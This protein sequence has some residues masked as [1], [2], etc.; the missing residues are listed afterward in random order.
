[1]PLSQTLTSDKQ[2]RRSRRHT[3]SG[4]SYVEV[5]AAAILMSILL[6]ASLR[7][8]GNLGRSRQHTIDRDA[9]GRLAIDMIEEIRQ[10]AYRD[11]AQA[12]EFGPGADE[13][14]GGTRSTFDDVD[15][16]NGWESRPPQ[17]VSGAPLSQYDRLRRRVTVE[18]V[19]AADF[20]QVVG[21]DQGF[22]RVQVN[23]RSGGHRL[24]QQ[25]YVIADTDSLL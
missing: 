4:F 18:Y 6:V 11:P 5:L 3:K 24:Q 20:D 12:D 2:S 21:T 25:T 17:T 22:L 1:M 8:F 23:I 13:V 16:Y 9:A 10:K 14:P 15:D 7:L 19:S